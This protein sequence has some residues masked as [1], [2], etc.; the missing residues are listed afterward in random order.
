MRIDLPPPALL[1]PKR[2]WSGKQLFSLIMR[3]NFKS[4]DVK[5]NLTTKGKNYSRNEEFCVN[6]SYIIIRNGELIAGKL[7]VVVVYYF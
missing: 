3:P 7:I 5:L 4:S 2:L 6:D 1:K